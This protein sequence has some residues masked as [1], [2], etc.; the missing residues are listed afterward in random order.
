MHIDTIKVIYSPTNAQLIVLKTILKCTLKYLQHVSVQSLH[1]QG[2]YYPC[3]LNLHF[4]KIVNY[5][6]LVCGGVAAYIG[7]VL[8]GVCMSHCS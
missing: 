6:T 7:G 3:L 8:V 5:D 2:D 4:V 1:F